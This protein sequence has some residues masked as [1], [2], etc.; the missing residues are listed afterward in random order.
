MAKRKSDLCYVVDFFG[1]IGYNKKA[2]RV[3]S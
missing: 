2:A 1:S 3:F